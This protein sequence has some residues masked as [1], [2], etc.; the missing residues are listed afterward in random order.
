M[1]LMGMVV[2]REGEDGEP[3]FIENL[4]M[5]GLRFRADSAFTAG[6]WV[7]VVVPVDGIQFRITGI[8]R[9][10]EPDLFGPV[11]GIQFVDPLPEFT[12]ELE[13]LCL[14]AGAVSELVFA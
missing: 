4:G 14:A 3:V 9:H 8:V 6:D 1:A 2:R 7:Q 13:K 11:I 10:C 5:G 12:H